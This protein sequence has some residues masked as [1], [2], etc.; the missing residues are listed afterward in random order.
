MSNSSRFSTILILVAIAT[1]LLFVRSGT[2]Q[3]ASTDVLAGHECYLDCRYPPCVTT[4]PQAYACNPCCRESNLT[5]FLGIDGSKQPQDFG[6]N[7]NLGTSLAA[8]YSQAVAPATGVGIQI[9]TRVAFS[10]NAVQVY[11]LLGES[12]NRFQSFTTLGL[13]QRSVNGWS[14]GAAYDFLYQDSFD[15]F[16][17]GQWRMRSS[18]ELNCSTEIGVNVHLGANGSTGQFNSTTVR[19]NAIDQ[20]NVFVRKRWLSAALTTAWIGVADE[21]SEENAVTGTLPPK[22]NQLLLGADLFA[23]LNHCLAIYGETNL[24][25]PADTGTVDAF[26]GIS[27]APGGIIRSRSRQNRYREFIPVAS[28]TTFSVDLNR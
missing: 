16:R 3:D 14:W 9:G 6:V 10:G 27:F 12:D 7:A 11:E 23:P 1:N 20:M 26:L 25:M 17:L 4:T 13:F 22:N 19:L 28:S 2:C 5:L 24:M 8:S 21:H 18:F 15:E